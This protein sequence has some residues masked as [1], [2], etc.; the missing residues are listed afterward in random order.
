[1][2]INPVVAPFPP[3]AGRDGQPLEAGFIYVGI[4]NLDPILNPIVVYWDAA[5]TITASQP[6]RTI[7]G[8]ASR[9]GSPGAL[10]AD[11][12]YSITINDK[13]NVLVVTSP[14]ISQSGL[15]DIVLAAGE[16]LTAQANSSIAIQDGATVAIG[17]A[18][19]TGVTVTVASNARVIGDI[20]PNA[21]STQ[22]LGSAARKWD[23]QLDVATVALVN[24]TTV[25]GA[26]VTGY[27]DTTT[28]VTAT[29]ALALNQQKNV[30]A[31]GRVSNT[32]VISTNHF[33]LTSVVVNA[34]GSYTITLDQ[35]IDD[36]AIVLVHGVGT[37][38]NV[39]VQSA[40]V[41]GGATVDVVTY[42]G[43]V[44]SAIGFQ[45]LIVGR[46]RGGVIQP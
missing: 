38:A 34:P 44:L 23:A 30:V 21:T 10:F 8:Y 11:S 16:S 19:G 7:N 14:S 41:G 12:D 28:T 33:N 40:I 4:A 46:P 9:N 2:S 3:F 27:A 17:T 31:C 22:S 39:D 15:G 45:I 29:Q 43:G 13:Q 20:I 1:V 37:S 26:T 24:A 36:D 5:L 25:N 42:L 35:A 6:I 18:T 32:G